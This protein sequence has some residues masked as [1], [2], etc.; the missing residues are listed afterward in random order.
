MS[1]A[2]ASPLLQTV[3]TT[4]TDY[5]N[6]SCSIEEL[7]YGIEHG[8]VGATNQPPNRGHGAEEG[9]P[10]L[11]RSHRPDHRGKPDLVGKRAYLEASRRDGRARRQAAGADLRAPPRQEGPVVDP[12]QPPDYR[13]AEAI[14]Q[15]A[16][17]FNTLAPNMQVKAPVTAAGVKAIEEAT[18]GGVSVNATVSFTVPQ[19]VAV[20]E[21]IERGLK[22]REAAS[23]D[24]SRMAPV[25]HDDRPPR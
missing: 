11:A 4:P 3:T 5:W 25:H 6:D 22:R 24:V 16:I 18:Y 1:T 23:L 7:T 8:A 2:S 21:A 20:G 10:P 17:Y 14:T 12:N 19:M 13:N 9:R 15:Q